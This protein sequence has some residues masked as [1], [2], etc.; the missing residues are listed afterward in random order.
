MILKGSQ[1]GGARQL[2]QHLLRVDENEHVEV[3]EVSGF[4]ASD[5]LG[6]L[7]EAEAISRGT[8][9]KQPLFSVSLNPPEQENVRIEVFEKALEAIEERN[10]L[11]G[12]PRVVVFHEKKGRRHCHAVWSRIDAETMTARPLPFFKTKLRDV[13]KQLYLENGWQMPRGLMDSRE[14]DP[15]NF[16]LAE[17]QQAKR[18]GYDPREV[19]GAIQECWAVSDNRQSFARALEE[20][21]LYLAKGDRRGHVAVTWQGE[22]H[23]IAR[24]TGKKVKEV[25]AKLGPATD[26]NS[27]ADTRKRIADEIAPRLKSYLNEARE[28]ARK[29][30]TPLEVQRQAMA[31]K[32][33]AERAQ[34]DAGIKAREDR[35]R[36]ERNARLRKGLVGLWDRLRGEYARRQKQNEMEALNA[37]RRDREQRHAFVQ[38]QLRERVTLQAQIRQARAR[39]AEELRSLH[40]DAANYRL[41]QRGEAPK[42]QREFTQARPATPQPAKQQAVKQPPARQEPAQEPVLKLPPLKSLR[43][44]ATPAQKQPEPQKAPLPPRVDVP[45]RSISPSKPATLAKT[46]EQ[47]AKPPE[48]QTKTPQRTSAQ[49]RLQR[50]REG[51]SRDPKQ[52]D[53][54]RDPDLER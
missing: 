19:K 12:Q 9:C 1:R 43:Q 21:G 39:H 38:D 31:E 52:R 7:R 53:R 20:R 15:R 54:G 10:G 34:L 8:R 48:P 47:A 51:R 22:I 16:S 2:G 3:H 45:Q 37:L 35:E 41:M 25:S 23:S 6:A 11:Q 26:L 33:R 13:S 27:V 44:Q 14:R 30:L 17:W 24:V 40:K 28:N 36:A 29:E 18:G 32:H 49:D 4:M 5:L 46:F 42:L 50:L